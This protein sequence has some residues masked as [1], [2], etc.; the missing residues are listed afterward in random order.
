MSEHPAITLV[1]P[2]FLTE[3]GALTLNWA[4][5]E[6]ALDFSVSMIFRYL[7]NEKMQAEIPRAL[8]KK[9]IFI[10]QALRHEQLASIENPSRKLMTD[11]MAAKDGRHSL[12]HGAV[13]RADETSITTLRV[14][15]NKTGHSI[16]EHT[17]SIKD[18]TALAAIAHDLSLR[19][20]AFSVAV[21][22]IA[23]PKDPIDYPLSD[24]A[25]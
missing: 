4:A 13:L 5:I 24:F 8:E 12:V 19:T 17:I 23:T 10:R 18:V 20:T 25:L 7:R 6:G 2:Q 9:I 14:R 11:L 1:P 3:L 22:N 16:G 15:Y 21:S